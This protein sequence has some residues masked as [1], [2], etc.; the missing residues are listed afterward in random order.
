MTYS[1]NFALLRDFLWGLSWNAD[2]E[3]EHAKRL[4]KLLEGGEVEISGSFPAGV[5]GTTAE[6]LAE[7][8]AGEN[9][10]HMVMYPEFAKT[11]R[12]EGFDD[13]ADIFMAIAV[14]EKQHEKRYVEL[15]ANIEAG[16]VFKRDG[17][18][19]WRCRNCGYL[20][21]G[22]QAPDMCPACDHAQKHFE[23]LGE[24]W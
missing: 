23:L 4:F 10:E 14:A 9:H 11:A 7:S 12:E 3:K 18:E 17:K 13:I 1:A 5:V 8:A 16:R 21:E 19:T 22:D 15:K 20:H 24:N 2:Q 6:N